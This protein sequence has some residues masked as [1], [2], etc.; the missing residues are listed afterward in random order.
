MGRLDGRVAVVTGAGSGIGE[1]SALRFADEG[2]AVLCVDIDGESARRTAARIVERGGRTAASEADVSQE[3]DVARA[4][5]EAAKWLGGLDIIYNNAGI[6]GRRGSW[7]TTL[8][9]NLRGV[10]HGL[11]L[12]CERLAARG[13]GAIV[14]TASV[15]GLVSLR[16]PGSEEEGRV[17]GGVAGYVAAKHGVVGL[18]RQFAL[19][20]GRRGVRVNAVA[21]GGVETPMLLA[22]GITVPR[23]AERIHPMDR[24]AKPE[25]VAAAALF[26][27]SDDASFITGAVLPVDGGYTAV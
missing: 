6:S 19:A 24:V 22:G 12:G 4:L 20:Y 5:D 27:V 25:E 18:T 8:A 9:V 10:Y 7:Q 3:A 26:L 14:S 15:G 17:Q 1:A 2:A 11:H 13:G 21:P 16:D 23:A